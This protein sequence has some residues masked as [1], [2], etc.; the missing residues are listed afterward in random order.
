M[1]GLGRADRVTRV[2]CH[3]CELKKW[4]LLL[5]SR[6]YSINIINMDIP[7]ADYIS[8]MILCSYPICI[9]F[10]NKTLRHLS[11]GAGA[12]LK[13]GYLTEELERPELGPAMNLRDR[14][15]TRSRTKSRVNL[16]T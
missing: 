2:R 3:M 15:R 16:R 1:Q 9:V 12:S 14:G 11:K 7:V 8:H 6:R 10:Q 13:S 5:N 4:C